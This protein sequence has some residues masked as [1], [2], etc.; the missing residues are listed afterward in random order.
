MKLIYGEHSSGKSSKA[1]ELIKE[2]GRVFYLSLDQDRSLSDF[3]EKKFKNVEHRY[4]KNCFLIDL[5]FA[6]LGQI[7]KTIYDTIV[8]DSLNFIKV[9]DDINHEFNLRN[10]IKGLEYLHY[11]YDVD[12]I[13][14]FNIL[15][16]VDKMKGD[17]ESVFIGK[18]DWDL[19][20]TKKIKKS[21]TIKV[22]D[23]TAYLRDIPKVLLLN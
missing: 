23:D 5:E 21:N 16:N 20:E 13:A 14:I 17:I 19:I 6:I 4:I 12:I 1:I 2:K 22:K 15:K 18:K 11:T 9:S 8:V 10:I 3:L 7:G